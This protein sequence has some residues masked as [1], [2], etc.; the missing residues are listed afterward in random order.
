MGNNLKQLY[1]DASIVLF[2]E[3]S[4][5]KYFHQ[6][7]QILEHLNPPRETKILEIGCGEGLTVTALNLN[8]FDAYG[9]EI[10]E[11]YV[12][13]AVKILESNNIKTDKIKKG[14]SENAPFKTEEFDYVVSFQV[15]E[16]VDDV[17]KT[18]KETERVLKKGGETLQFCPSYHSFREEHFHV[19]M[20]PFMNKKI[21]YYWLKIINLISG[22]KIKFSYLDHLNFIKP[23]ELEKHIFPQM[24]GLN[25]EERAGQILKERV[26]NNGSIFKKDFSGQKKLS[27]N[28]RMIYFLEKLGLGR[29]VDFLIIKFRIYPRVVIYGQKDSF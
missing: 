20:L 1:L 18:F 17:L 9:L 16:H 25:L 14:V 5:E 28:Y 21:F 29:I 26:V 12:K 8:G 11:K 23:R 19:F 7:N 15:L 3:D 10:D 27:F 4:L 2:K 13:N 6:I 24:T 22:K